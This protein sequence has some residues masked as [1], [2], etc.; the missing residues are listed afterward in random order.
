[1]SKKPHILA[2][3]GSLAAGIYALKAGADEIYTGL[4]RFSARAFANNP[5]LEELSAL[6]AC[7]QKHNAKLNI[8]LNTLISDSEIEEAKYWL[9]IISMLKV[10]AVI[11]QD[12]GIADIVR[13]EFPAL[14]L[15]ASTQMAIHNPDGAKM[16]RDLGFA[17]VILARELELK[18]IEE[19]ISKVPDIE[20]EVFVSGA[21]CYST[22]GVCL[23]SGLL[24]KR[25]ANRGVC[26][27]ICRT[28]Q[29]TGDKKQY[30]FS[31]KDLLLIEH[32]KELSQIGITSLKIEGR[33][34]S[35]EYVDAAVRLWRT[36][37]DKEKTD[38]KSLKKLALSFMRNTAAGHL[39]GHKAS[40][41]IDKDYPGHRG[42]RA[43]TVIKAQEKRALIETEHEI[44][45]HDGVAVIREGELIA[46][47]VKKTEK[48]D[49]SRGTNTGK[50]LWINT[51]LKLREKEELRLISSHDNRLPKVKA[52]SLPK[53]ALNIEVRINIFPDRL[54]VSIKY[55]RGK[56]EKEFLQPALRAKEAGKTAQTLQELFSHY[57]P[58]NR[59]PVCAE[60][61]LT[62]EKGLDIMQ[63]FYPLSFLKQA[64]RETL[65]DFY[66]S[67]E[68]K[69]PNPPEHKTKSLSS[70]PL[71]ARKSLSPPGSILPFITDYRAIREDKLSRLKF[72]GTE[73]AVIPLAPTAFSDQ[74]GYAELEKAVASLADSRL[75]IGLN[76]PSHILWAKKLAEQFPQKLAFFTDYLLYNA[77]QHAEDLYRSLIPNLLFCLPWIESPKGHECYSGFF[78]PLFYSRVSHDTDNLLKQ[79]DMRLRII[80]Q[81]NMSYT[82]LEH[83]QD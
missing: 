22:S 27:Q 63:V 64:R 19:I 1:M 78:P 81:D 50:T 69:S 42:L 53:A 20:Y 43:G 65:E 54:K 24:L 21:M 25:S 36:K 75:L 60:V 40:L 17:R 55:P 41:L 39:Y 2:P 26:A 32:A 67:L 28:W 13:K 37:L 29:Q 82:I 31:M 62:A 9:S 49:T 48:A 83:R 7:A 11:V 68:Q 16:M 70:P 59:L 45:L 57:R 14:R 72:D 18:E 71:P 10:D 58:Q 74:P 76:N 33:M 8:A 52:S 38:K 23:A 44:G 4:P 30:T 73:Y 61:K 79:K 80:Y 12:L 56:I 46:W 66:N 3:A 35:P 34:K 47:P 77:N 6:K 15:H 51:P 5:G